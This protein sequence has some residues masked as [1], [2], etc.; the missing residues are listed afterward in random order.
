MK[1]KGIVSFAFD[2]HLQPKERTTAMKKICV[3]SSFISKIGYDKRSQTLEIEFYSGTRRRIYAY[4]GV[5]KE[6]FKE[7]S[8]ANSVGRYFSANIRNEYSYL[9]IG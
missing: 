3:A 9:S 7:L 4:Y 6:V 1:P 5:S 2:V 8:E